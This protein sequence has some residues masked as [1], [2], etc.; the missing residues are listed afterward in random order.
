M[1]LVITVLVFGILVILFFIL[2]EYDRII[3]RDFRSNEEEKGNS[4]S[5]KRALL[6]WVPSKHKSAENFKNIIVNALEENG[7]HI[8]INNPSTSYV[9]D[10]EEF[11]FIC[12]LTPVYF[13]RVSKTMCL[14]MV[15]SDYKK[16]KVAI[17]GLGRALNSK[18]EIDYMKSLLD[19]QNEF[20]VIKL[21]SE[22]GKILSD[23]INSAVI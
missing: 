6:L 17:I 2:Y 14:N 23:F 16:K 21:N 13:G 9:Y 11:D 4:E 1:K 10:Y 15:N 5:S 3:T 20:S 19:R 12:Y 8:I 7:F 22:Q 18:K